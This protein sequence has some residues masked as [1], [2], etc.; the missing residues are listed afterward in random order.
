MRA[1]SRGRRRLGVGLSL[2]LAVILGMT[3]VAPVGG[4]TVDVAWRA[5]IGTAGAN[6]TATIQAYTTGSG[7][8]ALKLA[9]LKAAT[10]LPVT[11]SK[12]TCAAVG[13]RLMTFPSIRTT[14]AGTAART[15]GLTTAQVAKI[16]AA[17]IGTGKMAIRVGS[18][19]T[20]GVRCGVFAAT[21]S[22]GVVLP[23]AF[24]SSRLEPFQAAPKAAGYSA[25]ILFSRDVATE[26][27]DVE[28]LIGRGIKV[29]ILCPQDGAATAAAADEARAAGVKVVSYA[30]LILGAAS[31]DY[32]VDFD[33]MAVGAAQAQYLID[34][35]G[36]TKGNNLY[37]YAGA[38]SDNN[39]FLILE[40]AWVKL[41]P[42]IVDGTF[43]IRNSGAAVDLQAN[44]SV[45]H[46]Q[47]AAIIAQVTT[48]WDP[49]TARTV[50][51]SN[52]AVL[53]VTAKGTV[54]ILAP[55]D[56]TARAIEEAF[57][58]DKDVTTSS[59]TGQDAE[60]AS[61]QSII[62][63][64]Q[65]MTVFKDP[66]TLAHDAVAAAVAF[67][68]G[69]TPVVTTTQHNGTIDVPSRLLP[70]AAVTR[71]N[72]QAALIDTGYYLAS[73]FTGSWPGKP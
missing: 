57:A 66:R 4:A 61:V 32:Y 11:L 16:K 19:R 3:V 33:N 28:A 37:L 45:T 20:G 2:S 27:T 41:Q 52:L 40:G 25:Q 51:A 21:V 22:I 53:P 26:K 10:Y 70:A 42:K 49:D 13:S 35:A 44:P 68:K 30:R 64:R 46:A 23:S 36:A 34:K 5:K 39:S 65:G 29:L 56:S 71:D 31:V 67:M 38:A 9:K 54:F 1:T 73:D 47:A 12:G 6:G 43:V 48:N 8:F 18:S 17:T 72:V 15:S 7:S 60:K 63:G 59:V 62:D 55:N 50:A 24:R 69:R 14:S 58:S